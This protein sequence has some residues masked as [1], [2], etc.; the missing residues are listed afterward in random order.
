MFVLDTKQTRKINRE[1]AQVSKTSDAW[2]LVNSQGLS[3]SSFLHVLIFTLFPSSVPRNPNPNTVLDF[4]IE[5]G[6][7]ADEAKDDAGKI[8]S[9]SHIF[10]TAEVGHELDCEQPVA[11]QGRVA[12]SHGINSLAAS[13]PSFM[14]MMH[15]P[16][17]PR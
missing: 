15:L 12:R 4:D 16:A 17:R 8:L 2:L 6:N 10:Y 3:V 7:T 13:L 5:L 11:R 1:S 9:A 14:L